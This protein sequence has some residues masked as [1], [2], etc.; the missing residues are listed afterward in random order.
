MHLPSSIGGAI[1]VVGIDASNRDGHKGQNAED[2]REGGVGVASDC[3][4]CT[5]GLTEGE[6]VL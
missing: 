3:V 2:H 4:M 6:S 1:P 5:E